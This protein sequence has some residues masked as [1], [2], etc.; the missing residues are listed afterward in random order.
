VR[1]ELGMADDELL[2][3]TIG[4]RVREKGLAEFAEAANALAGKATFIWV[5]P[6]D[7]TDAAAHAPPFEDAVRFVGERTDMPAVYSALDVF[8]LASYREGFSRAAMEAAACGTA[9]VLTDIRGC[10]EVGRHE[11]HL[12]LV[13]PKSREAL[14]DGIER[15]IDDPRLRALL[16]AAARRRALV[17][18]D[19]RRVANASLS[20]YAAVPAGKGGIRRRRR[21]D[22]VHR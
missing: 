11:E 5:G 15:L 17:E 4:R 16:G 2:V 14:A 7:D 10:R 8:V 20:T 18:F 6:D 19:Q 22:A 13:P 9:M 21:G 1:A 3:G 12:L